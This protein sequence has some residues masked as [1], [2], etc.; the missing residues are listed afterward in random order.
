M[1]STRQE[2]TVMVNSMDKSYAEQ[3]TNCD[4][5]FSF[6]D[7]HNLN[8]RCKCMHGLASNTLLWFSRMLDSTGALKNKNS[9]KNSYALLV[10]PSLSAI[11]KTS[12][13]AMACLGEEDMAEMIGPDQ[14]AQEATS[15]FLWSLS[16]DMKAFLFLKRKAP[17][18]H[19]PFLWLRSRLWASQVWNYTGKPVLK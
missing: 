10:S 13:G 18:S 17:A 4:E 7:T 12:V 6:M 5:A 8:G 2:M 3:G 9:L 19:H 14:G 16:I 1:S 15:K 11:L